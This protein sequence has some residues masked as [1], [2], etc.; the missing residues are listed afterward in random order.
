[1]VNHNDGNTYKPE[2]SPPKSLHSVRKEHIE[3]VLKRTGHDIERAAEI[4]VVTPKE[5]RRLMKDLGIPE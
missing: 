2:P 5:L 3:K 1:M 4:L